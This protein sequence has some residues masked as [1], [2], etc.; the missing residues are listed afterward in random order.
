MPYGYNGKILRVDLSKETVSFETPPESFYRTYFGGRAL[1]AYYL[2]REVPPGTDPLGRENKLI[3][4]P[5]VITGAPVAGSGR[6]SVG[7]K[8]PLTGG[9]GD[10]EGG[11]YFGAELKRAGW[12]AIIVEGKASR[13]VY[14][15]IKDGAVE[16]R[17]GS[18]IWGK[19]TGE[20]QDIIRQELGDTGIRTSQCGI[21]G[22]RLIRYTAVCNDLKHFAGRSGMGAVMGSKNLRAVAVRGSKPVEVADPEAVRGFGKWLMDNF[23]DLVGDMYE[24]GTSGGVMDLQASSGLPTRNFREGQFEGAEKISG[25][26]MRDT[27]L[28]GRENCFACPVRCKRVVKVDEPYTVDPAYGGP[29]YETIGS[30]GSVCGID[31]L[32]AIAKGHELCGKYSLD[33]I[34]TGVTIAFAM[35]CFEN[36]IIGLDDTGGI[37]LRFGNAGAMLAMIEKIARREGIGDVLAEGAARAAEKFGPEAKKF[38]I[39]VKGQE[40]PMHE[41]RLKTALGLGYA[42]SPT[43]ADHM[44]NIHDTGYTKEGKSI[45]RMRTLGVLSPLPEADLSGAKVRMMTY[46]T[47][48]EHFVNCAV[49][50]TFVPWHFEQGLE[51][52]RAVTGWNSSLFELMKVGERAITLTR[53]FNLAHGLSAKDDYLTER[54]FEPFKTGPLAGH[55]IDRANFEKAKKL[56]YGMLGWS[57]QGVPSEAKLE[58]LGIG[59]AYDHIPR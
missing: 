55:Q 54:F 22:E 40:V 39:H 37:D 11:G 52:V 33:T 18:S 21:A 9:Y 8:S 1:C 25:Q 36:G 29:E 35:E 32:K 31:D 24:N 53:I 51:L 26:T 16:I 46:K 2:L 44:H 38:A 12:D 47:V 41:P 17:D 56:H 42:V 49:W 59:W 6:N 10:G 57:D 28:V 30:L 3:F 43:G 48:W 13:P 45:A 20:A 5:G 4:A 23:D 15:W 14:L 58:E 27:I 34:S 50:C 19:T 7:A